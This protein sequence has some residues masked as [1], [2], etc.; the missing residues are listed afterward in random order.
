MRLIQQHI[1]ANQHH[2]LCSFGRSLSLAPV[3]ESLGIGN[4]LLSKLFKSGEWKSSFIPMQVNFNKNVWWLIPDSYDH[5]DGSLFGVLDRN[6]GSS[7][8]IDFSCIS[9]DEVYEYEWCESEYFSRLYNICNKTQELDRFLLKI[10]T[11]DF[12]CVSYFFENKK[13]GEQVVVRGMTIGETSVIGISMAWPEG[14]S[15]DEVNKAPPKH[16]H[17]IENFTLDVDLNA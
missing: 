2:L 10:G 15:F 4:I 7:F 11:I 8:G 9:D 3:I 14:L 13:Y 6:D 16:M 12:Q 1:T 5:S 17:F